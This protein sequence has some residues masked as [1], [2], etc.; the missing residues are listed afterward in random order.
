MVFGTCVEPFRL[1]SCK[2][3]NEEMLFEASDSLQGALPFVGGVV[4]VVV[5]VV[6]I[7]C[8]WATHLAWQ[9]ITEVGDLLAHRL[10]ECQQMLDPF[11]IFLLPNCDAEVQPIFSSTSYRTYFSI[12]QSR[13]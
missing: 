12:H 11:A 5:A 9:L 7:A 13:M 6:A 3:F 10:R 8:V 2:I 1:L 4:T